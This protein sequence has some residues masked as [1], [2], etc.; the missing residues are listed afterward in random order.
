MKYF[1]VSDIHGF[2]YSLKTALEQ[3]GFDI[4]DP[5]QM[6]II[7]G[8]IMDRGKDS[9]Q[10]QNYIKELI[11]KGKV[12][13]IRGNHEDLAIDLIRDYRNCYKRIKD[14]HYYSNGTFQTLLIL[15]NFTFE[16]ATRF[17]K[18]FIYK[19][20]RVPYVK[21]IIPRM[22]DYYETKNYIFVH[23]WIP[24]IAKIED[25]SNINSKILKYNMYW[26][27]AS[28]REWRVAR[29]YDGIRCA[30][31]YCITEKNKTIVC[32][33]RGAVYGHE[34]FEN[35]T[36]NNFGPFRSKGILAIDTCT[37]FSKE[38]NCVIIEDTK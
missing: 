3:T 1:V 19:A 37:Y 30:K 10:L 32:G 9:I 23:G 7:C 16:K 36:S 13:L 17:P 26:R 20:K 24:C 12:I 27:N 11:K 33:H 15:T 4:K 21:F 14:T 18:W 2:Y 28:G 25:G 5:N 35:D 38:V 22:M 29:W 34:E 6:L 31:T 8:D